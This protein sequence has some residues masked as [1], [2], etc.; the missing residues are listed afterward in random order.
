MNLHTHVMSGILVGALFF[1]RPEI[2][3]MIGVGS[4]IPDLDREYGFFSKESF[5]RRQIHRALFHNFLAIAILYFI[6]PYFGIGAFLHAFLDSLTTTRDRGVEWLFPFSRLVTKAVYDSDGNKLELDPK[7]RIYFL[8]NDLP[9]LTRRT[10]KDIKPG[11]KPL[12][13]RRTYGPALSG[14]F[15]DR[16]LFFGSAA[17]TLLLLLFSALGFQQFIDL[18]FNGFNLPLV[19][20]LIIGAAGVFLNFLVGELDRERLIDN[21]KSYRTYKA[22]FYLS[23]GMMIVAVILGAIMNPQTVNSTLSNIPYIAVGIAIVICISYAILT[24]SS[25]GFSKGNKKEPLIV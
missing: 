8:Q 20:P 10:T 14:K 4:A 25:R 6:N 11:E 3:L 12:P 23:F 24:Y 16:S 9:G 19:L 18:T 1:G 2:M 7:H 22:T 15:L 17:L 21:A 13:N 5:R